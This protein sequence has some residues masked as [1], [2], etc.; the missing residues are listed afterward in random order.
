MSKKK[1]I[2]ELEVVN[3]NVGA[4]DIGDKLHVISYFDYS[5]QKIICKEYGSFTTDLQE[6]VNE[7][8]QNR[9]T[10][11]A[12]E[13][14][15]VY[16][17]NLFELLE[18][19][20][21]EANLVN[22]K[23]VK[24]VTGRKKDDTDSMW[25]LK[26]HCYGLLT[27][28]FVPDTEI[29]DLRSLM[30]HRN[31]LIKSQTIE[32]KRMQKNLELMN[33]KVHTVMSDITGVSGMRII[34]AIINGERDPKKLS[35]LV[36][37]NVKATKDQI[38]KSLDGIWKKNNLFCLEQYYQNYNHISDQIRKT[39]I[40]I[41]NQLE[42]ITYKL[43]EGDT[44]VLSHIEPKT[45]KKL[46]KKEFYF[47]VR[48]YLKV[49]WKVDV[50][51]IAGISEITALSLLSEIGWDMSHWKSAKHF[52]A[53]LNLAPNTKISGGSIISSKM[54]KKK[55]QAGIYLR[56]AAFTLS[57]EKGVFGTLYRK[58]KF[59]LGGK[60][61]VIATAHKMSRIIYHMISK[62]V[63]LDLNKVTDTSE[64]ARTKKIIQLEKQL[65][66]LKKAS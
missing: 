51:A 24:N 3:P 32:T 45:K 66:K 18:Q 16:W 41:K 47:N 42:E 14:T 57:N 22:P 29:K 15:G 4:V 2:H 25:I 20:G 65:E 36:A 30:R 1:Q 11:V 60:G 8:K 5:N 59:H 31:N 35:T 44:S 40:Q 9:V 17:V 54:Q 63:E 64:Q 55:N 33:I 52:A 23:H 58:H 34:E 56:Q 53:W 27:K 48:E 26:L 10:S 12:I 28:S 6:I 50:I 43:Y 46:K 38:I 62:Q 7:F 49:I 19:N 21:I 13:S 39:E 61:A 37:R